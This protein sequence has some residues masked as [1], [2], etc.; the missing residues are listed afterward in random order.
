MPD[1]SPRLCACGQIIEPQI[2]R[3]P[4]GTVFFRGAWPETCSECQRKAGVDML[5]LRRREKVRELRDRLSKIIPPL[6]EKARMVHLPK[7]LRRAMFD[8]G[9]FLWGPCGTG[10]TYACY[11]M[12]RWL[13]GIRKSKRVQAI[14]FERLLRDVR[15]GFDTRT[16]E[17]AILRPCEQAEFL[18]IDD[19]AAGGDSSFAARILLSILDFRCNY[20][21]RTYFTSNL[22]PEKLK[23]IYGQRVFSR[24]VGS[25]EAIRL[26]GIDKR[27][28]EKTNSK[29]DLHFYE[30][31]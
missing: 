4:E 15:D 8:H 26:G 25:C 27:I 16:S 9:C 1:E 24:I 14:P 11:A 17:G 20:R 18:F 12:V 13:C 29:M 23:E 3:T 19:L 10:K 7:T 5:R 31:N 22:P 2:C 30:R 21:L 6:Y 28:H